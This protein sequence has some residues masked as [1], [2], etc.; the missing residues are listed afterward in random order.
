MN[1]VSAVC[2]ESFDNDFIGIEGLLTWRPWVGVNYSK[3]SPDNRL[4]IV[5]ESHYIGEKDPAKISDSIQKHHGDWSVTREAVS[6]GFLKK[7]WANPTYSG[8]D[9]LLL[10]GETRDRHA[11]WGD[12]CFYNFIQRIMSSPGERPTKDDNS[13]GWKAFLKVVEILHPS[14]C[15][16]IGVEASN[17][18]N[19]V[20]R[21]ESA[22]FTNVTKPDK[23]GRTWGR[24][25]TLK[26]S[27]K[28]LP[29]HFIKHSGMC[30]SPDKWRAYLQHQAPELMQLVSNP[31][32]R[33]PAITNP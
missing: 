31:A 14:H 27:G 28:D 23:V 15:L 24:H 21:Q 29:I 22:T 9:Q 12:V 32:Y 13:K 25:A 2:D 10:P 17:H 18:F 4:L 30:F 11:F 7:A 3:Q 8:V 16:F 5:G 1:S 19:C 6:N 20:M 33:L 26:V